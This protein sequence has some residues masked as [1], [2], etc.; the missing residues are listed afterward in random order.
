MSHLRV[1]IC[2]VDEDETEQLTELA[3]IDL[4][5][6]GQRRSYHVLDD[7]EAQVEQTGHQILRC[8]NELEWEELD[9]QAV[10]QYAATQAP[11]ST[12]WLK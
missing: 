7:L 12:P 6:T 11:A 8:L 3:S 1:L 5:P 10:C 2:R 4:P 9:T